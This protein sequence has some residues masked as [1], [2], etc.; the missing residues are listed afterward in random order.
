MKTS[1][2]NPPAVILAAGRGN[3]LLPLT[4]DRPKCL[5]TI[6]G[7]TI[8][9]HQVQ[10]LLLAGVDQ[11]Q[12]V[13]GHGAELVRE[14]CNGIAT[15]AHNADYDQ[16][17]SFDSLACTNFTIGPEGL[18]I[19]N[20]DVL[21]HPQLLANLLAD[22]RENVLLA[23]FREDLGE[24]EMKII[25]D[26]NQRIIEISKSIDPSLAQAENLGVL[27]LGEKAARRMLA[28]G[29]ERDHDS[30]IRWVP[31]GI[32]Y[33]RHEFEFYTLPVSGI[34]WTEIDYPHDLAAANEIIYPQLHEALWERR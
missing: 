26:S 5:L 32:H 18:L 29:A 8:L 1:H 22:P 4:K 13:T 9:Q 27:K 23:D 10:A 30:S 20:S 14:V 19:L 24:E 31:D 11:I 2:F 12:V 25:V 6:G 28:L 21:F 34:P 33:L 16:T 7:K 3:R 17:N 15:Y